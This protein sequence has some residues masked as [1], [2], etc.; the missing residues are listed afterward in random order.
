MAGSRP[1]TGG[2]CSLELTA[3]IGI[4]VWAAVHKTVSP[5]LP[6]KLA[7]QKKPSIFGGLMARNSRWDKPL[8]YYNFSSI[9]VR[10]G[11]NEL[12]TLGVASGAAKPRRSLH[13]KAAYAIS[14]PCLSPKY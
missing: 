13:R 11:S 14:E 10:H 4:N 8:S 7:K 3:P 2:L 12:Y 9:C 1:A 5:A 6:A